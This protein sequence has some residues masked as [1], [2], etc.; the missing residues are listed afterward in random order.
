LN[1]TSLTYSI[2]REKT[3]T[4]FQLSFTMADTGDG[5]GGPKAGPSNGGPN[6]TGG[7]P[8]APG[9]D[10]AAF[11]A[12]SDQI[13]SLR[14]QLL[15]TQTAMA[16]KP[17]I[18]PVINGKGNGIQFT[19]NSDV[20]DLLVQAKAMYSRGKP[21]RGDQCID[22][23]VN[24]LEERNK[25]ILMASE[26]DLGWDLVSAYDKHELACDDNDEKKMRSADTYAR[27][28]KKRKT[29]AFL[30]K[31]EKGKPK[32]VSSTVTNNAGPP[33]VVAGPAYQQSYYP[34]LGY[35]LQQYAQ[36]LPYGQAG[37][38]AQGNQLPQ[39]NQPFQSVAGHF[40]PASSVQSQT[41]NG[42]RPVKCYACQEWGHIK[43]NCPNVPQHCKV[44]PVVSEGKS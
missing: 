36:S 39:T 1:S 9:I 6:G 20:M 23:A 42:T 17:K 18:A 8:R 5:T 43:P 44:G 33:T 34:Q 27:A 11:K 40:G 37:P 15:D 2:H 4:K 22:D 30:N 29:E 24:L 10:E 38:Y 31:K 25:R 7:Q 35:P 32:Q 12:L 14:E 41:H 19:L 28:E 26:S 21:F 13:T 3:S 16:K